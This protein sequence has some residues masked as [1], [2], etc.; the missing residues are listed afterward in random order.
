MA[1]R[2]ANGP[3]TDR[4]NPAFPW[5]IRWQSL[6]VLEDK[7]T[8]KKICREVSETIEMIHGYMVWFGLWY[9]LR[10]ACLLLETKLHFRP[11][12]SVLGMC[13]WALT[14]CLVFALVICHLPCV[15]DHNPLLL[16]LLLLVFPH[17][18]QCIHLSF[19]TLHLRFHRMTWRS[20]CWKFLSCPVSDWVASALDLQRY[21]VSS[22][23]FDRHL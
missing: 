22:S 3:P 17:D 9:C 18:K 14:S 6:P 2:C 11:L 19:P 21:D 4:N 16:L 12:E 23:F 5:T 10:A 20:A 8:K 7:K 1:D 13:V 15:V